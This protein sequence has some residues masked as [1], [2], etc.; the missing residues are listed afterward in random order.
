MKISVIKMGM[1]ATS[2]CHTP[3]QDSSTMATRSEMRSLTSTDREVLTGTWY[4][5]R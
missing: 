4:L 1:R 2:Y 5:V 3:R